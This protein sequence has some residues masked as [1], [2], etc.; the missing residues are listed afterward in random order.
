M[1]KDIETQDN[2]AHKHEHEQI[3]QHYDQHHEQH[4]K[5]Q[6]H[7]HHHAHDCSSKQSNSKTDKVLTIRALSGLSG[8]IILC[9]LAQMT[10][11]SNQDLNDLIQD[12]KLTIL[13]PR[14]KDDFYIE[15]I[16]KTV[17]TISGYHA[18]VNIPHEHAHRTLADILTI[19]D[20][21]NLD[22]NA[23]TLAQKAFSILGKAEAQVHGKSEENVTFHEVGALDSILDICLACAL[24]AK[25]NPQKTVCS[26][27]PLAD[28]SVYCAH[29]LIPTPAP[30]VL[31]LL[32]G[33]PVCQ[34]GANGETITPTAIALLKAF[35]VE[36]SLWPSMVIENQALIYGTKT[37]KGVA[38]GAIWAYGTIHSL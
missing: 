29:G 26:P 5:H 18:K 30:A 2:P 1:N 37:F 22:Q 4:H 15:I 35:G 27:L 19:I 31:K 6:H 14:T 20:K 16:E 28:G 32:E 17:N 9:G 10:K 3:A 21:S 25:L 7:E 11:S 8:D 12:I 23:K 34:F 33:V 13:G 38:N 24:F 36:F